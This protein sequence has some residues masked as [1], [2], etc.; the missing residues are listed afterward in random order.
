ML[1]AAALTGMAAMRAGAG[2]TTIAVA[3]SLNLTLQAKI[4]NVIMTRSLPETRHGTIAPH[5]FDVLKRD[6]SKYSVVALGPGM[7]TDPGTVRF[8]EKMYRECPL[9][10]VVDA[11]ALNALAG[12]LEKF[13]RARAARILTPHPG[14]MARLTG[15]SKAKIEADRKG[16]ALR[17]AKR[18]DC[19]VV[20]KG[21]RTVVAL[22][23]GKV[24]INHTG[25]PGMATAGSGD[26]LTGMIAAILAQK[27]GLEEAVPFAV[28]WHGRIGDQMTKRS[29]RCHLLATDIIDGIA[30]SGI[31]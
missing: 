15:L 20:L 23:G 24:Y 25:N 13:G 16:T 30:D 10:V 27:V 22:P 11:D 19:V 6:W 5:A 8:I 29:G 12:K 31:R 14:E 18:W 7:T 9:P 3:K 21:H 26:V 17:F 1:G 4:S 2:L 28:W